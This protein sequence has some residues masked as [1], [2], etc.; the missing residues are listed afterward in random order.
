MKFRFAT[1]SEVG[2]RS[3]NE[4]AVGGWSPTPGL[5]A[6][7]IADGLGGYNGGKQASDIAIRMFGTAIEQEANADLR[8]L[9]LAVHDAIRE[10]QRADPKLRGMATTLSGAVIIADQVN[11]VHCGD[12]RIVLQRNNGIRRLTVDHSE[13]QRLL[14]AGAITREEYASYP[15]KNVLESALGV[16]ETP[17][18]DVGVHDVMPGDRM[19]FTSDGVH[20]KVYLQEIRD[21]SVRSIEP[22]DAIQEIVGMVKTRSPEDNYTVAAVF[23]D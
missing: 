21:V 18:I 5:L 7:A 3:A 12:T 10:E 11:F 19:F 4:D 2:P 16:A 9:A 23:I 20:S 13:A 8:G 1:A 15:R 6:V 17:R 14:E 22:E